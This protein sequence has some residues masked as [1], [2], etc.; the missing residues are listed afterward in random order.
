MKPQ[1]RIVIIYLITGA[2]WIFLSDAAVDVLFSSKEYITFAQH[3]KGWLFIVVTGILLHFLIRRDVNHINRLNS[4]LIR[5]YDQTIAG[6]VRVMDLRH[7]ET[8]DHTERVTSMTLEMAKLAAIFYE[9]ELKNIE[10]GAI[11]HD[12]G[13][14]G[15]PDA[16]LIKP[17]K[18]DE[19]EWAIMIT[20]PRIARE[21]LSQIS[22]LSPSLNI[23]FYHH[24]KWDGTGY[25]LGLKGNDIP[26]E[27]RIFAVIDVWD[28][29]IHSRVYKSA[30]AEDRVLNHIKQESGR[31]FDPRIVQIFLDN[32]PRI[33]R[34]AEMKTLAGPSDCQPSRLPLQDHALFHRPPF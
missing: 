13:K 26:L 33:K 9:S 10:R 23:P 7:K 21:I 29:L 32:Y 5:S 1:H 18:L 3:I 24:E 2:L 34:Y 28:A 22:F 6:W 4:E 15:I 12:I 11:L 14:I 17:D 16:I 27:A 19:L 25:P 30:W 8:K 31:H 20:H